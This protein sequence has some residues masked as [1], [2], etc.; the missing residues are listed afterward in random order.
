MTSSTSRLTAGIAA[1]VAG[2]LVAAQA[3]VNSELAAEVN[4]GIFAALISF[5]VGL[6]I[7][8]LATALRLENR[9]NLKEV[10]SGLRAKSIP[11]YLA[12][13]GAIGGFFVIV[14]SSVAGLIGI[15]LFSVGVVTG[16]S[17]SAIILDGRGMLGLEKRLIGPLRIFG[18]LLAIAG[19]VVAGDFSNYAFDPLILLAFVAGFSI[20]FQQAMNGYFGR[21][22]KSAVIPTLFNFI[23]GGLFIVL[24][25]LILEGGRI[26]ES[27]P[28]NPVLYLGGI[29]GVIF[30]F[31]QTVVLPKIG[32][33][34][35]GIAMLVGQLVGSVLL[36]I[37]TPIASRDVTLSTLFGI[38][39]AMIGAALVAKR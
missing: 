18:T 39:L 9:K 37:F 5:G 1:L 27:L 17:F 10:L 8:S 4:S 22:A 29:V 23:A 26:P 30:I 38:V 16:T 35:M 20:G 19:L 36:D 12:I 28:S 34:T 15:S 21:L 25:L 14:Q 2:G 7:I 11:F 31:V 13:A 6:V 33:L 32:A 24:A 3:R